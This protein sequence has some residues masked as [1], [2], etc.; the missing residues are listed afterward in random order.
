MILHTAGY[1]LSKVSVLQSE[2]YTVQGVNNR[3]HS[4]KA[5]L[6]LGQQLVILSARL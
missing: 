4:R 3:F 2:F 6:F 1:S 5:K